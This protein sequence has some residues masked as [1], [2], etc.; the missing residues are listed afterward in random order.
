[1]GTILPFP[2]RTVAEISLR[3]LVKN[4]T[5]LRS[6]SRK[7]VLPVVKA[8]A[9]GHG[10]VPIAKALISRGSVGVLAVATLEEAMELRKKISSSVNIIVLSGFVPHQLDAYVKY[11]IIPVIHTL[12]H[13]KALLGRSRLPEIHLKLDSGMNRLGITEPELP[14][15]IKVLRKI[16]LKLAGL[17]S[18]FADSEVTTSHF[19]D[20]QTTAFERMALA[21]REER[22]LNTDA[23]IHCSN[24][25]AL[26]RGKLSISTAVRPGLALYGISPNPRWEAA[27]QLIPIL[28][29]KA[30]I[31][32]FKQLKKGSTVGYGRTYK[33]NRKEKL[34]LLPIGYADGYP[35]LLSN[36]GHVLMH[37]KRVPVRGR[38]SMDLTAVDASHVTGVRE[39][40][41][42]TLIGQDGKE[43]ISA[44]DLAHWAETIPYEILCGISPRV[45]RVYYD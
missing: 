6:L 35:R 28:Q 38:V 23:R 2:Y 12:T 40:S 44:W 19:I 8:D 34:A 41:V 3:A 7:E 18:H 32:C 15:T 29:W 1:M 33:A 10:V 9:Y 25:G 31:L 24:S 37:G 4:L 45:N 16:D 14:E 43:S 27:D 30:R 36:T 5:T 20:E 39:G 22:F 42:V 26:L 21:L 17:M 13:L 11:G